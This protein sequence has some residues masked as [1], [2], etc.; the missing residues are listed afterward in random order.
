M[1]MRKLDKNTQRAMDTYLGLARAM[2]TMV[3]LLGHQ[4]RNFGLTLS[5]FQMLAALYRLGSAN[6]GKVSEESV[7]SDSDVSVV[8]KT[9]EG[10]GLVE[11]Y[12]QA[13]DRRKRI[14]RLTPKG[15]RL[16]ARI[17]PHH[18]NIVRARMCALT[19]V[20]QTSLRRLCWK[21]E[22]GNPG[23]FVR[24]ITRG[25][26]WQRSHLCIHLRRK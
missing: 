11:R 18:T 17:Y 23:R 20:E 4:L 6:Q 10:R 15:Q 19:S 25:Y 24:E 8:L 21:L 26:A 9:L 12:G 1:A 7:R 22:V 13:S 5:Q 14:A 3:Q 2:N 16:I